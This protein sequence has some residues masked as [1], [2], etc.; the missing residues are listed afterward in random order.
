MFMKSRVVAV[1]SC[2]VALGCSSSPESPETLPPGSEVNLPDE[3]SDRSDASVDLITQ[4]ASDERQDESSGQDQSPDTD[5]QQDEDARADESPG[6]VGPCQGL[7][8]AIVVET[9]VPEVNGYI[10]V[11]SEIPFTLTATACLKGYIDASRQGTPTLS[12]EKGSFD[13]EQLTPAALPSWQD[14]TSTQSVTLKG[15]ALDIKLVVSASR[16]KAEVTV[17]VAR[18]ADPTGSRLLVDQGPYE[19]VSGPTGVDAVDTALFWAPADL[20]VLSHLVDGGTLNA[21]CG[22]SSSNTTTVGQAALPLLRRLSGAKVYGYIAATVDAPA[23]QKCGNLQDS[24]SDWSCPQGVCSKFIQWVELLEPFGLD[25]Y[26]LDYFS[27]VPRGVDGQTLGYKISQTT[28]L[29]LLSYIASKNINGATRGV[30]VNV[31][32][33]ARPNVESVV[34]VFTPTSWP[35]TLMKP[36]LLM[37]GI[38][39]RDGEIDLLTLQ[40]AAYIQEDPVRRARFA[41]DFLTTEAAD[42]PGFSCAEPEVATYRAETIGTYGAPGDTFQYTRSSLYNGPAFYTDPYCVY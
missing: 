40:G 6:V 19:I 22:S 23:D 11:L 34:D 1:V 14:G 18:A 28:A 36:R 24:A 25:G 30:M 31:L 26:F 33:S 20:L 29:N 16:N 42:T 37:E 41:I 8:D 4:D 39:R 35:S 2:L 17:D 3:R 21:D 13:V 27:L 7:D 9:D 38:Y 32:Y 5:A 12:L 15:L 10:R